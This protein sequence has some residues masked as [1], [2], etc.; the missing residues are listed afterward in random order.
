MKLFFHNTETDKRVEIDVKDGQSVK[1]L[2]VILEEK[3]R[4]D[5]SSIDSTFVE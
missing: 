3:F 1:D 4:L 5:T 2:K